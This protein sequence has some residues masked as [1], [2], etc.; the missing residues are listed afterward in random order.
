M[1][2]K[3]PGLAIAEDEVINILLCRYAVIL[4][5]PNCWG[6]PNLVLIS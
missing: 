4:I 3:L 2:T 1:N 6:I 5:I